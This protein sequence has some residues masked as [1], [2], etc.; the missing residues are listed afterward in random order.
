MKCQFCL[1]HFEEKDIQLSHDVPK[2]LF[3]LE[4]IKDNERKNL[5]DK[6]TRH[7]LCEK[8]HKTYETD[9]NTFLKCKAFDFAEEYFQLNEVMNNGE[10]S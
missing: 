6:F 4:A 7:N 8:C 9:L 5:A 1:K 3:C 10:D 2:Y